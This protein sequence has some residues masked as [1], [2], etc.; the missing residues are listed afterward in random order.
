[1]RE[2]I[3]EAA[4][5]VLVPEYVQNATVQGG[6]GKVVVTK[7]ANLQWSLEYV[8]QSRDSQGLMTFLIPIMDLAGNYRV[9]SGFTSIELGERVAIFPPFLSLTDIGA[10]R[11]NISMGEHYIIK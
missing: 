9:Y 11:H 7:L 3:I 5:E 10:S 2:S 8:V 4:S 1:M 6:I